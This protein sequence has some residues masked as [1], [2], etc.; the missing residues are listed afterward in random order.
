MDS[1][2]VVLRPLLEVLYY[3]ISI[4]TWLVI[5]MAILSW[6]IAFDVLNRNSQ[7][8]RLVGGFLW[9]VTEPALRPIRRVLPRMGAL[10]ISPVI[11]LLILFFLQR[12]IVELIIR[13][14]T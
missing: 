4:Y 2:N 8:V 3:A 5:A 9:R 10:D 14:S 13:I 7:F 1:L 6:L 11:L 12:V